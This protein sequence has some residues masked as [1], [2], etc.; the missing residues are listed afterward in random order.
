M[1]QPL[2]EPEVRP[3]QSPGRSRAVEQ[4][5]DI[6]F[7]GR[8]LGNIIRQY[9]GETLFRRIEYIRSTSVDRY[10]GV[11]SGDAVDPGLSALSQDEA[12]D[13]VRGFMLFSVLANLAE[14]RQGGATELGDNLA[15]AVEILEKQGIGTAKVAELLDHAL[16]M[17]VLTAHPTEVRRKSMIDHRNRIA[18]LMRMRDAGRVETPDCEPVEE[19]IARQVALLWLTRPLRRERLFV[20]DEIEIVLSYLRDIF[21]PVVPALYARWEAQQELLGQLEQARGEP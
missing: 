21:L 19:A 8:I 13:F 20:T 4:N 6:R 18:D 11:I 10:R 2:A 7:L 1:T 9:G 17:P 5:P 3:A 12:L 14:D 16:I 15:E